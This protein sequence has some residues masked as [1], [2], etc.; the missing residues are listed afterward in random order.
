MRHS[1]LR[2]FFR[3]AW[4]ALR[5]GALAALGRTPPAWAGPLGEADRV[6]SPS[7]FGFHNALRTEDG[8]LAFLDFEYAGW[9]DPAKLVCDFELQPAVPAP[10]VLVCC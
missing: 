2:P 1:R 5:A 7:D 3:S 9:D 8:R 6:V 4:R 10:R